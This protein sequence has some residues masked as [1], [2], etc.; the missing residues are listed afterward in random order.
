MFS[1]D[2]FFN[3]LTTNYF[4]KIQTVLTYL[5]WDKRINAF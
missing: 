3:V 2:C 5:F 4:P 1:L